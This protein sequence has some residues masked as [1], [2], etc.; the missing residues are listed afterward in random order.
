MPSSHE[1]GWSRTLGINCS[2]AC[3]PTHSTAVSA[4]SND[5]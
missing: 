2:N 1:T 3:P 5:S 4:S